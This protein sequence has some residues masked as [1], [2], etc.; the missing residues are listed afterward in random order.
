MQKNERSLLFEVARLHYEE[1]LTQARVAKL[2]GLT[3]VKVNRLLQEARQEGI[4]QFLVVPR[5]EDAYLRRLE[6]DLATRY[7]LLDVT[8]IPGREEILDNTLPR[9]GQ[10]ALVEQMAQRAAFYLDRILDNQS[11]M[12]INWGRVMRSVVDHLRPTRMLRTL[13]VLP[14]LGMLS[15]R[16]DAFEANLLAREVAQAY[17]GD[18]DWLISPAIVRDLQQREAVQQLP[19]VKEVLAA[20]QQATVAITAIAPA[21]SKASTIVRRGLLAE[22]EVTEVIKMGA[23]GE[24]CSWWFNENGDEV[25]ETSYYPIGLG[26]S[27]LRR[28]VA[29]GKRVIGVV[30]ADQHRFDAIYAALQGRL[31]NVLVTDHIT[32]QHLLSR[33]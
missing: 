9:N 20:L 23:I 6:A 33:R 30:G 11:V 15:S 22:E 4:V 1:D 16:A 26:L 10:Q 14:F 2:L 31:I 19:L 13:N 18:Y 3:R 29:E 7:D 5:M 32:A 8:L 17:G 25:Q 27:G 21:D 24:I 28:M 12:C